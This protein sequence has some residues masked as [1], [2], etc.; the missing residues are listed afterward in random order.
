MAI[1]VA[2]FV[3]RMFVSRMDAF[4]TILV[5]AYA[6]A[7]AGLGAAAARRRA[8]ATSTPCARR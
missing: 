4:F 2:L 3:E 8:L 5:A 6:G 1:A 7:L